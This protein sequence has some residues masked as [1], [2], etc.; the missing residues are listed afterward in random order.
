[1][2]AQIRFRFGYGGEDEMRLHRIELHGDLRVLR[3][4][5]EIAE[6]EIELGHLGG[7][8]IDELRRAS[9]AFAINVQRLLRA[10]QAPQIAG[11]LVVDVDE[12]GIVAQYGAAKLD[13]VAVAPLLIEHERFLH[14]RQHADVVARILQR[15]AAGGRGAG[16]IAERGEARALL[17]IGGLLRLQVERN[18]RKLIGERAR[19]AALLLADVARLARIVDD[20]VELG[21]RSF[22]VVIARVGE[23][24]Q[25]APSEVQARIHRL[26]VDAALRVAA[27]LGQ[28]DQRD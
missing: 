23:R 1:G 18:L 7:H 25:L 6:V 11:E 16:E 28:I 24:A 20:V 2:P 4:R 21:L 8:R 9:D 19:I 27:P 12:I 13:A 14:A 26:A 22:D 17:G 10:A 15:T 3:R 5:V